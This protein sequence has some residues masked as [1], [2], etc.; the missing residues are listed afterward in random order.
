[1]TTGF[2]FD[3]LAELLAQRFEER[4]ISGSEK[5]QLVAFLMAMHEADKACTKPLAKS[6]KGKG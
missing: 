6:N 1:M 3:K 2:D 4:T 5:R